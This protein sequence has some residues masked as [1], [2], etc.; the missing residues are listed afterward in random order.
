M[1]GPQEHREVLQAV[2]HAPFASTMFKSVEMELAEIFGSLTAYPRTPASGIWKEDGSNT[3][4]DDLV[5][6][7]IM[8]E[9]VNTDW[10]KSYR[11]KLE[12]IFDQERI[13]VRSHEFRLL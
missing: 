10:W 5:I 6:Y 8:T 11:K 9:K 1:G 12:Q 2:F 7:E 13:L 3:K 4:R